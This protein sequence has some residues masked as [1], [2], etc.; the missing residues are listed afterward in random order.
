M[1]NTFKDFFGLNQPTNDEYGVEYDDYTEDAAP[2]EAHAPATFERPAKDFVAS[3][4]VKSYSD[5][6]LIGEPF[7][8]G[9]AVIFDMSSMT[10]EEGKRIFDFAA[11]LA[12][13]LHG[14]LRKVDDNVWALMYKS[15]MFSDA[16]LR[17]AFYDE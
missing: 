14:T 1:M 6:P 9:D 12:Y 7:K 11:G 17:Q 5:A 8:Q 10:L 2:R 3:V 15:H 16:Q 4:V 13:A